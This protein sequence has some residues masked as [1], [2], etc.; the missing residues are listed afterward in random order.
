MHVSSPLSSPPPHRLSL[1]RPITIYVAGNLPRKSVTHS[2]TTLHC[3]SRPVQ[4]DI[5]SVFDSDEGRGP[6][7]RARTA[8][9]VRKPIVDSPDS[10]VSLPLDDPSVVPDDMTKGASYTWHKVP[11]S[12]QRHAKPKVYT[13]AIDGLSPA[14][15]AY[16]ISTKICRDIDRLE[17]LHV[18]NSNADSVKQLLRKYT[19]TKDGVVEGS[20]AGFE[21]SGEG[22]DASGPPAMG[23]ENVPMIFSSD[24]SPGTIKAMYEAELVRD[25]VS[26]PG[27]LSHRRVV[28]VAR[29]PG[30]TLPEEIMA[31]ADGSGCDVLV[32]G[33]DR[34][35][36]ASGTG[37][38]DV[39]PTTVS[40]S[41]T[42]LN[43]DPYA[44]RGPDKAKGRV[45]GKGSEAS[46]TTAGGGSSG[47][48]GDV[49]GGSVDRFK[50][51]YADIRFVFLLLLDIYCRDVQ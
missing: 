16:K 51:T 9:E 4:V 47:S 50:L 35:G 12:V 14:Y 46:L 28:C 13:C 7:S 10:W 40:T 1:P 20:G 31:R 38:M 17:L 48:V 32:V 43:E 3:P 30:R 33:L 6:D 29:G 37:N 11:Y 8:S 23:S 19:I 5:V 22:P 27:P 36:L 34:I 41:L 25:S 44:L 15:A 2:C 45:R 49:R 24:A 39:R 26:G 21:P 18:Y 42:T